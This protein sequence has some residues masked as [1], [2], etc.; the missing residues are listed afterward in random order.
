MEDIAANAEKIGFFIWN[1]AIPLGN[2][3]IAEIPA[4]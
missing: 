1:G 2:G 4:E 3:V